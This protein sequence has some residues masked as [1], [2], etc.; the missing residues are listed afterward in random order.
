MEEIQVTDSIKY[1]GVNDKDLDLFESQYIIPNGISYNSYIIKDEKIVVMDTVDKR[2]QEEWWNNLEKELNGKQV[3]YLVVLHL[4]PDH[5]SSIKMLTEKYPNMKIVGNALTF[6]MLPQFFEIDLTNK[7]V[8]V[9]EGDTLNLGKHTLKFYMA[10][11][12]HWPEVMVTYEETEKILFTADAFGKFGSLDTKEDWTCEARRYYFNIVGKY[13]MQVQALLKKLANL[14]IRTICPL[15]GPILKENLSYYIN[16]YDIWSSYKPEDEGIL[17]AYN[18]IHGNTKK[19]VERLQEILIEA[20]A[21]KVITSDLAR[22]DMAEV[23]EDAFRYDKMILACPTY[24]AGLFPFMEKFLRH[25][26]HKNY[27]NRTVAIIENG[28]W[29]PAAAKNMQELL[30]Q[31]KEIKMIEPIIH[32]KTTMS[33]ENEEEMKKLAQNMLKM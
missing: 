30:E 21:K 6:K 20:G 15:H 33:I 19:A 14:E 13:G 3:D 11:M 4:E 5:S 17:I 32:I 16:K 29:A 31:M 25:L 9:K 24:D 7:Q 10:P 27:Q 12:V 18:S 8:L 28:S 23:I 26:K 22:Q 1:I 2:K